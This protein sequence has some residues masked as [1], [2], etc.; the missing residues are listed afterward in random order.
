MRV[1]LDALSEGELLFL[2]VNLE[3][4]R[5]VE[6]CLGPQKLSLVDR[7]FGTYLASR[8][9]CLKCERVTWT[10]DLAL[11]IEV[12][13]SGTKERPALGCGSRTEAGVID[14]AVI[15]YPYAVRYPQDQSAP[16]KLIEHFFG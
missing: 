1:L 13:L 11:D 5:K 12:E 6:K 2:D 14:P 8:V 4:Y 7:M 9:L 3:R 15:R 10:V 16:P